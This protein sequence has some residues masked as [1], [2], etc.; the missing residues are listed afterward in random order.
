MIY[1]DEK[2][3]RRTKTDKTRPFNEPIPSLS[4]LAAKL[5][6]VRVDHL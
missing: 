2:Q 4:R 3:K 1:K 6:K 5:I